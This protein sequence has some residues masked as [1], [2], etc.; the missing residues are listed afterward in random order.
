M[1]ISK[2]IFER[3]IQG[4][5]KLATI[6]VVVLVL[7]RMTE[8]RLKIKWSQEM[9]PWV[10]NKVCGGAIRAAIINRKG[11]AILICKNHNY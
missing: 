2:N 7:I 8:H 10:Q 11:R 1:N 4:S 6:N 3:K 9:V 5:L